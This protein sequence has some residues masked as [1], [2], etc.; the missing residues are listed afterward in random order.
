MNSF[1]G[2]AR[3]IRDF[4]IF[5]LLRP[6]AIAQLQL[7]L[8]LKNLTSSPSAL[9]KVYNLSEFGF[10]AFSQD[11][12]DGILL[13]IFA[14]I[15]SG[16]KRCVEICAGDGRECNTANLIINHG[17][18][19]LLVDGDEALVRQGK[20]FYANEP[21]TKLY[22]PVF[23][24]AWITRNN[25]NEII[26]KNHFSGELDLLSLDIDGMDYWVWDAIDV[27]R[28]RVVVLEY[29]DIL[30]PERAL[31]VPYAD[32]FVAWHYST[33]DGAPNYCGASLLAFVKLARTKGYRLIGCNRL[34]YNAFFVRN[35]L[36]VQQLPEVDVA[37]CVTHPRV[38]KGMVQRFPLVKEMDWIEV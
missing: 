10:R 28:P 26:A 35:G 27:C 6:S 9:D 4:L 14:I 8:A 32:D 12:E 25:V 24:H 18:H 1:R 11:D 5:P 21:S 17:W 29:Q 33:T 30:G 7:K 19:G 31:T 3:R 22:P 20:A 36:G 37:S 16:E 13:L 2:L 23:V 38:R 34:G 15:G